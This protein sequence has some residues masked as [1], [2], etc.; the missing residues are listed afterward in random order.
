LINLFTF[1]LPCQMNIDRIKHY[2]CEVDNRYYEC[3]LI[4]IM[5]YDTSYIT[6]IV[7]FSWNVFFYIIF[8]SVRTLKKNYYNDL[9]QHINAKKHQVR[10]IL[11]VLSI[12]FMTLIIE[13]CK[14]YFVPWIILLLWY[15][16]KIYFSVGI[17]SSS[18]YYIFFSFYL[19]I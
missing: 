2:D 13:M 3:V 7:I 19:M 18:Y 8:F 6:F 11:I 4:G 5:N 9:I 16:Y 1:T 10:W 15:F 12:M 14:Y 17:S